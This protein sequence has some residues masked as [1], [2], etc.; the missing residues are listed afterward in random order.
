[1]NH[2]EKADKKH[3]LDV[4]VANLQYYPV[5]KFASV[6]IEPTSIEAGAKPEK[7]VA[8]VK[9]NCHHNKQYVPP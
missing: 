3:R 9:K 8:G 1:V 4:D 2:L 6:N 7:M 5:N